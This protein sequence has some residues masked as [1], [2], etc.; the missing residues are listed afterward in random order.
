MI[1]HLAVDPGVR[2]EHEDVMTLITDPN[3]PKVV[4][5]RDLSP[6]QATA[7]PLLLDRLGT[8]GIG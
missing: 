3:Y 6:C 5:P 2:V 7:S 4:C 1:C 8:F